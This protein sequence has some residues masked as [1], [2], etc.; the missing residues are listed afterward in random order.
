MLNPA[1]LPINEARTC[2]GRCWCSYYTQ[3]C[4]AVSA[5]TQSCYVKKRNGK[6]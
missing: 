5:H 4:V 2:H 6:V 1:E 3:R